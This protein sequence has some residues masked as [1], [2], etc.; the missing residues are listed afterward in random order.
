MNV[1]SSILELIG[2][3]PMVRLNSITKGFHSEVL[4]KLEYLNP[5]GSLKDRIALEMINEAE[6]SGDLKPGYTIVDA[7]T[8]NTG[9][10]LSFVGTLKGYKVVIYQATPEE[11]STERTKIMKNIG[12]E[13]DTVTPGFDLKEKSIP[14]AEIELPARQ[15]CLDLERSNPDVWWARQFSNPANVRAHNK[16]GKEILNQTNGNIDCFV[17]SIGTGGTLM[18]IAEVLKEEVPHITIVGVE[19]ASS[20][21]SI[22]PGQQY[23]RSEIKGGIISDMLEKELVDEIITV[24][25]EEAVEMTHRLWKEEGLFAGV[26]SGANVYGAVKKVEDMKGKTVVTILPDSMNRYLTEEHYIT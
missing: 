16:T 12:A 4:V 25:N 2:N 22:V 24:S 6:K 19:P 21:E 26:S 7:S 1:Y 8:G 23:P 15:M 11:A 18:G 17:A 13:V 9:I 5:S 10:S 20:S 3:T 14:G